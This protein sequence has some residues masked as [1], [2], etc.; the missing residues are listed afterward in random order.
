MSWMVCVKGGGAPM[1]QYFLREEAM[2]EA[3]RFCKEA[4]KEVY[5]FLLEGSYKP[6]TVWVP[7]QPQQDGTGKAAVGDCQHERRLSPAC[8]YCGEAVR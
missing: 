5:V 7:L 4:Q 6:S 3:E 2:K 1:K 8:Y